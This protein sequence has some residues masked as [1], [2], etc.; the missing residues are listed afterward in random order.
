MDDSR[1]MFGVH[2]LSDGEEIVVYPANGH[3]FKYEELRDYVGG[4][5]LEIINIPGNKLMVLNEVGKLKGLEPNIKAT[6]LS[7]LYPHDII[8]G[9]VLICDSDLI[10]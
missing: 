3:D 10:H 7:G 2:I 4:G 9:D 5:P 1:K 8:V 6:V